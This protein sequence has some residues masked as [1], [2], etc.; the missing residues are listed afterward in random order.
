[1]MPLF[2]C[3]WQQPLGRLKV[4][5][6][7]RNRASILA[8][9]IESWGSCHVSEVC[10]DAYEGVVSSMMGSRLKVLL[11]PRLLLYRKYC[12]CSFVSTVFALG[13]GAMLFRSPD[14]KPWPFHPGSRHQT[15]W[16]DIFYARPGSVSPCCRM[17]LI[18]LFV[19]RQASC[20]CHIFLWSI[21]GHL[22]VVWFRYCKPCRWSKEL[23]GLPSFANDAR[24]CN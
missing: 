24:L 9:A 14:G 17:P 23:G 7:L 8:K 2:V 19:C 4:N 20:V 15:T 16:I 11:H 1:M 22:A 18:W 5:P 10:G 13:H 6:L 12:K 3:A 21:L